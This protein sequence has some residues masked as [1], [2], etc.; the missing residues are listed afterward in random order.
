[1]AALQAANANQAETIRRQAETGMAS[2]AMIRSL[3][4]DLDL[5]TGRTPAGVMPPVGQLAQPPEFVLVGIDRDGQGKRV[6]AS[7]ELG[8][9]SFGIEELNH[10]PTWKFSGFM[11]NMLVTDGPTYS[12]ALDKIMHIWANWLAPERGLP[13]GS[14]RPHGGPENAQLDHAL[15]PRAIEQ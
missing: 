7:R 12:S 9:T 13:A 11:P 6:M 14:S 2:R 15:N 1:V 8:K 4:R 5:A 10:A 3:Q